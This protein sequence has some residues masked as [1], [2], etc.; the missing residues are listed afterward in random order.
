MSQTQPKPMHLLDL[1]QN[2]VVSICRVLPVRDKLQLRIVCKI[3]RDLLDD[4][5]PGDGVWG[6]IELHD[7]TVDKTTLYQLSRR[8]LSRN[9]LTVG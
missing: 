2:L 7:F 9:A 5:T 3:F 6:V 4:P 8:V 1:D